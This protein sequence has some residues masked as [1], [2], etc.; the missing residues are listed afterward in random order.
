MIGHHYVIRIKICCFFI[1]LAFNQNSH[2][3]S[4]ENIED[5]NLPLIQ[6]INSIALDKNGFLWVASKS[7]LWRYDGYQLKSY[8]FIFNGIKSIKKLLVDQSNNLWIGTDKSGLFKYSIDNHKLSNPIEDSLISA[9]GID[10][11]EGIW[12]ASNSQLVYLSGHEKHVYTANNVNDQTKNIY[13]TSIL[14]LQN[15]QLILGTKTSLYS[16]D[17]NTQTFTAIKLPHSSPEIKVVVIYKDQ[18]QTVWVGTHL[19]L[20]YKNQNSD[21]FNK[22]MPQLLT[23]PITDV[24]RDND[25]LWIASFNSGL[26]K[27]TLSNSK[28]SHHTYQANNNKT[29]SSNTVVSLLHDNKHNILWINTFGNSI[30]YINLPNLKFKTFNNNQNGIYCSN[31]PSYGNMYKDES[32]NIWLTTDEGLIKYNTVTKHCEN[33]NRDASGNITFSKKTLKSLYKD[34]NQNLWLATSKGLNKFNPMDNS[35]DASYQNY[36]DQNINFIFEKE[37]DNLIIGTLS[38]LYQFNP[39]TFAVKLINFENP[40]VNKAKFLSYDLDANENLYFLTNAGIAVLGDTQIGNEI[41]SQLLNHEML[42]LHISQNHDFWIGTQLNGIYQFNQQG[43]L[44]KR[45][46]DK[47]SMLPKSVSIL[48]IIEDKDQNIW[49][50]TTGGLMKIDHKTKKLHMFFS[51]DGIQGDLFSLNAVNLD[52]DGRLYFGGRKGFN[53]FYPND[54]SIITEK[55]NIALTEFT[56]FG[57]TIQ[58]GYSSS[59][60]TLEKDINALTTLTLSHKDYVIGF[61][62]AALDFSDPN[63]NQYAFKM[64]G[65]D[66]DWTYTDA[67]NRRISYSNLKAGEYLFN[68]KGANKDGIWNE[69]GK[70]LKV[71]VKPAPWFTWWAYLI[72]LFSAYALMAFYFKKKNAKNKRQTHLLKTEVARQTKELKHQKAKVEDLLARKN[73]M[74]ANVSHEF[75]TPLTLILGPVNQLLNKPLPVSD[76]KSLKMVQRNANRLLTMIEQLLQLSRVLDNE[77]VQSYPIKTSVRIH[78]IVESFLPSAKEKK[79]T[80]TLTNNDSAAI[81]VS[82]DALEII[83]GN[84]LSNAIKYTSNGG[85]ITVQ[86]INEGKHI[87]I[88]VTDTGPGLDEQQQKDIFTRFKRLDSHQNIDGIGIGLS[89]VEQTI[90]YNN[91]SLTIN[92]KPG[93]GSTFIVTFKTIDDNFDEEPAPENLLIRQLS[94]EKTTYQNSKVVDQSLKLKPDRKNKTKETVLIIDDNH[95]MRELISETLKPHY[96]LLVAEGGKQGVA[97]A[98]E[99]VPD[100]IISDVMMPEMDGFHVARILRS[101]TRTS[102]VPLILLT[103][104]D[105]KNSRIRGWREHVDA[106]LTKPFDVQELLL[107]LENIIVIRN[108]L[109]IKAGKKLKAGKSIDNIDLPKKDQEFIA[110]LNGLIAKNYKNP[111]YLRSQIAS[112][113]AVSERQLQR[114]IKALIDKNPMNLLREYRLNQAAIMLKEGHQVSITSDSCGFNS[115]P[116]FSMRFKSQFGLSP[117]AYQNTVN[118]K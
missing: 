44:I 54:I 86:A 85:S 59:D 69:A 7:N 104:L 106:Y 16:F 4:F 23:M 102:H 78:Q 42:S 68:V 36:M 61:E 43:R 111:N 40:T 34:S 62:F 71:I 75:R 22:Y 32:E 94:H 116:H 110:K 73:E 88:Q 18:D 51:G 84:L 39:K 35:I 83:F 105:D 56:R 27:V 33:Y 1:L 31:S 14:A 55:P 96:K 28:I 109:K 79:L 20:Y 3:I 95:D 115:L 52:P 9:I 113:M 11:N 64:Q 66:P 76:I 98:I 72:Y 87:N 89:V 17:K 53:Y 118:K 74:F 37:A 90:K 46:H 13:I 91:A 47:N 10:S 101:D 50:G 26:Y 60:F 2:A 100:V 81:S 108:I 12:A 99:H 41:Q 6:R 25:N 8:D 57:K 58:S 38:G 19:G 103:A 63:R 49:A 112:D 77:K 97:L 24:V 114:K 29:L 80:L 92:S 45:W 15:D 107:Q 5:K 48:S 67:H 21:S 82:K 117:K 30:N 70:T 65:Q 93:Q